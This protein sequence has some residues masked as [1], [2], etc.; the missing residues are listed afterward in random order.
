MDMFNALNDISWDTD[1]FSTPGDTIVLNDT[2]FY[3][4]RSVLSLI[5]SIS[6]Y[7]ECGVLVEVVVEDTL[8]KLVQLLGVFN[9][10]TCQLVLGAGAMQTAGLKNINSKHLTLASQSLGVVIELVSLLR[11]KFAV[12]LTERHHRFLKEFDRIQNDL[13]DHRNE[14]FA[15]LVKIMRDLIDGACGRLVRE[16]R[17][18][19]DLNRPVSAAP[20]KDGVSHLIRSLMKQCKQLHRVVTTYLSPRDRDYMFTEI[21]ANFTSTTALHFGGFRDKFGDKDQY[22]ETQVLYVIRNLSPMCVGVDGDVS[23][24]FRLN[25]S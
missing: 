21:A 9:S 10:R 24:W 20:G 17:T 5:D 23:H 11:A 19:I 25:K 18:N 22:L 8:R 15:K 6:E 12:S 1:D 14:I 13:L 2:R 7:M 3:V 16:C 4:V